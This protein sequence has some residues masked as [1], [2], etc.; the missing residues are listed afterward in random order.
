MCDKVILEN[1]GTLMFDPD[2]YKKKLIDNYHYAL[3]FN[4][5]CFKTQKMCN[6]VVDIYPSATQFVPECY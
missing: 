2:C 1:A 6:K 5:D 3:E 4:P